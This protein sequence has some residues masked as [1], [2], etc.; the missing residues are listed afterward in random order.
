MAKTGATKSDYENTILF[1][2]PSAFVIQDMEADTRGTMFTR[3]IRT[4]ILNSR[5]RNVAPINCIMAQNIGQNYVIPP[6]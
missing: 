4:P 2:V 3:K 5:G 6:A 1:V